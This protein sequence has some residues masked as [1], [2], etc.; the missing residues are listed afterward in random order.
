[1]LNSFSGDPLV[2]RM[3]DVV[4][5][6]LVTFVFIFAALGVLG[7]IFLSLVFISGRS[8]EIRRPSTH[9]T[10]NVTYR[11]DHSNRSGSVGMPATLFN[12]ADC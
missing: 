6:T 2:D 12:S 7:A 8:L 1:M 11:S 4:A 5:S 3:C 10:P 9:A